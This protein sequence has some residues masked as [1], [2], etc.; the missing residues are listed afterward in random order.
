M[1]VSPWFLTLFS[2]HF[3]FDILV[4]VYDVYLLEGQK[5]IYRI[6]LAIMKIHEG[7]KYSIKYYIKFSKHYYRNNFEM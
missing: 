2:A 6:A 4:R 1:Y 3:K 7:I 5:V